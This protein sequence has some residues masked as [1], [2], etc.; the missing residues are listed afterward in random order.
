ML[1]ELSLHGSHIDEERR[2]FKL[3]RS[4][5]VLQLD[6]TRCEAESSKNP[7]V[8]H[9]GNIVNV[10]CGGLCICKLFDKTLLLLFVNYHVVAANICGPL[11]NLRA[12]A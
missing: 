10:S 9:G 2:E 8:R 11:D 7:S 6:R 1:T 5:L 3:G 4:A 12:V